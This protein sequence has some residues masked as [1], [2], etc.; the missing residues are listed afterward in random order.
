MRL[1]NLI[2]S[3]PLA[4]S[5]RRSRRT[6]GLTAPSLAGD[7]ALQHS[8]GAADSMEK[9]TSSCTDSQQEPFSDAKS[10]VRQLQE[11]T[12]SPGLSTFRR[13]RTSVKRSG[14]TKRCLVQTLPRLSGRRLA[15]MAA[16]P[17]SA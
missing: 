3:P 12:Y 2:S 16:S 9:V 15:T 4:E 14:S 5:T 13:S 6:V 17:K 8:A 11:A 7:R 1:A 10:G